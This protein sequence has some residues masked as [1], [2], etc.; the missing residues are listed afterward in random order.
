VYF[1]NKR[2]TII[3]KDSNDSKIQSPTNPEFSGTQQLIDSEAGLKRYTTDIAKMIY[4]L[5]NL[6]NRVK[7]QKGKILEFGSGTGFLT[8]IFANDFGIYPHCVELDPNLMRETARKGFKSFQFLNQTSQDYVAI[9]TSNVLEH[10][11]DD[12]QALSDI[13]AS[14][15]SEGALAIYVPAHQFLFT[16]MDSD[17][18]H[19]RRYSKSDLKKKV[20]EAGFKV[21]VL[22]YSD[23]LG[24][25]ATLIVKVIGYRGPGNLGS[26]KTLL[27]YDKFIFPISKFLDRVGMRYVVGKNLILIARKP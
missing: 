27:L 18:G 3:S 13:F 26:T 7:A 16:Q 14:I 5:L 10:I 12:N 9:Y 25:F 6:E 22:H 24:F 11:E 4:V 21:D 23:C 19:V 17:V 2:R 1:K 8:Q 20:L 15:L